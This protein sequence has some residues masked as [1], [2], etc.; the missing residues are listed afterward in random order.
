MVRPAS[1]QAS[2][3]RGHII[4]SRWSAVV[5]ADRS[6]PGSSAA[7][8]LCTGHRAREARRASRVEVPGQE[9]EPPSAGD[10]SRDSSDMLHARLERGGV[11][12]LPRTA[13][14]EPR[15]LAIR[16]HYF[17]PARGD[18]GKSGGPFGSGFRCRCTGSSPEQASP[19]STTATP[20]RLPAADRDKKCSCLNRNI[21]SHEGRVPGYD[22][23]Q[24][25]RRVYP[26][27]TSAA[28][29]RCR[30]RLS[31][32]APQRLSASAPQRL[33][34]SAPQRLSASAPQRLSASAPQRL[35]ASAPQR[36]S[37]SAPQRLSASA[38]QRL[39]ASAPQRLSA[40]APL[41]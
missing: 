22:S 37:A 29:S 32:S 20:P 16:A 25:L 14:R 39:S 8:S 17:R 10:R 23:A 7:R 28:L 35:S 38:P 31:A 12:V 26:D 30:I 4:A 11:I 24:S 13:A 21:R 15:V 1:V 34:A 18:A 40:S 3:A 2:W 41:H 9:R 27:L 5:V 33:S 6:G 19:T 36:L